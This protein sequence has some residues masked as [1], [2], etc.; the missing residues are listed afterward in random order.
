MEFDAFINAPYIPLSTKQDL[1]EGYVISVTYTLF[2]HREQIP[3]MYPHIMSPDGS[4]LV[5][6]VGYHRAMRILV[7]MAAG[8]FHSVKTRIRE[9]MVTLVSTNKH[10]Y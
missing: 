9:K 7:D 5:Y 2:T 10:V 3:E 6:S 1:I 8:D 4:I